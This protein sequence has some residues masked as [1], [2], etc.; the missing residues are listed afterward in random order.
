M[1]PEIKELMEKFI[2]G[3]KNGTYGKCQGGDGMLEELNKESKSWLKT[4]GIP[5]KEHWFQVFRNFDDFTQVVFFFK[6][7]NK[8][9]NISKIYN[10]MNMLK[11][12]QTL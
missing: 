4:S 11:Y 1:P 7:N 9:I 10:N 8:D 12:V 3:S 6:H 2:S 5:T